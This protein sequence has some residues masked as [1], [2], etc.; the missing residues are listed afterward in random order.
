MSKTSAA[1]TL[2]AAETCDTGLSGTEL[3]TCCEE[4]QPGFFLGEITENCDTV[5]GNVSL[6]MNIFVFFLLSKQL[7]TEM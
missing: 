3:D 6:S 1:T 7:I 2:C 4:S 5:C